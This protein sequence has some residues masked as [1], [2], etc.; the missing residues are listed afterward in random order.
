MFQLEDGTGLAD[1]SSYVTVEY[2]DEYILFYFPE[3][4]EWES[5]T[6]VQKELALIDSTGF[7]DKLVNWN[8]RIYTKTQALS[9]PRQEFEDA[10]GRIVSAGTVPLVV[11]DAVV[12]MA[13]EGLTSDLH[14]EGI[15]LT[16]Q[17]YG[18]SSE[19]YAGPQRDGGNKAALRLARNFKRMGYGTSFTNLITLHRV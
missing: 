19:V 1:A 3:D 13:L 18:S 15:L 7:V 6:R 9:W 2:A 17:K 16:S 4:V 14:D 5:K 11:K 10:E 8:S 12:A